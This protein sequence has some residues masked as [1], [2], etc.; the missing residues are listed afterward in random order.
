MDPLA[1]NLNLLSLGEGLER[2]LMEERAP[3]PTTPE[4]PSPSGSEETEEEAGHDETRWRLQRNK[5]EQHPRKKPR[6]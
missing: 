4:P 5:E 6:F 2:A 1:E 3:S